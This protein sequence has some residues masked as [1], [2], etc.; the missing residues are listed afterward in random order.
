MDAEIL[1]RLCNK[2]AAQSEL[3][4]AEQLSPNLSFIK[5]ETVMA[6]KQNL[7]SNTIVETLNSHESKSSGFPWMMFLL[8]GGSSIFYRSY[9]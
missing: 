7:T 2:K 5:P 9:L 6:L 4:I 1:A 8:V 3:A